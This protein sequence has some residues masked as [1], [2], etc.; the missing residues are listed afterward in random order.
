[1]P[2]FIISILV[3]HF[4]AGLNKDQHYLQANIAHN[5]LDKPVNNWKRHMHASLHY[6]MIKKLPYNVL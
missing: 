5:F 4:R 6:F 1:M 2:L 3:L